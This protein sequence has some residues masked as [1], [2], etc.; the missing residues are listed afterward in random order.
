MRQAKNLNVSFWRY[1]WPYLAP[2]CVGVGSTADFSA[3]AGDVRTV[4]A[5]V[6]IPRERQFAMVTR[7]TRLIDV[8]QCV[9]SPAA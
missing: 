8:R 2:A 9:S 5:S 7:W 1:Q 6:E 3:A 4:S